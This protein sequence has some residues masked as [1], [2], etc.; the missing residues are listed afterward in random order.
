[1]NNFCA[2]ITVFIT[3]R[4]EMGNGYYMM[5]AAVVLFV[6]ISIL[7]FLYQ[8]PVKEKKSGEQEGFFIK[9]HLLKR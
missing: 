3:T 2:L 8:S 4:V 6:V 9:T 7:L 1:M 5:I